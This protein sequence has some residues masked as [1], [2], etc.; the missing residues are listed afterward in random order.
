MTES[1]IIPDSTSSSSPPALTSTPRPEPSEERGSCN[2]G[3]GNGKE[4]CDPGNSRGRP[5]RIVSLVDPP[6]EVG[7][8]IGNIGTIVTRFFSYRNF[9]RY[10]NCCRLS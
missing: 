10:G 6:D 8:V 5:E 7:I 2:R 4:N 1:S 3:L 9:L